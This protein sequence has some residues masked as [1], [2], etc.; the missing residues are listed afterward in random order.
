MKDK[1]RQKNLIDLC[2]GINKQLEQLISDEVW[3]QIAS[4]VVGARA[5]GLQRINGLA[6]QHTKSYRENKLYG[7]RKAY[8]QLQQDE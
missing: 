4:S 8:P 7:W 1:P 3:E 6:T 5:R 2:A